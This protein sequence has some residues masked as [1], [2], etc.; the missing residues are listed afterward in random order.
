MKITKILKALLIALSIVMIFSLV[1]CDIFSGENET[2][3]ESISESASE[4]ESVSDSVPGSESESVADS[5]SESEDESDSKAE[6]GSVSESESASKSEEEECKHANT[7]LDDKCNSVCSDCGVTVATN[8]HVA[9]APD[10]E[11]A[12]NVKCTNCGKLMEANKHTAGEPDANDNCNVKC[13]VCNE[14]LKTAQHQRGDGKPDKN[15]GCKI[16]CPVCSAVLSVKHGETAT[17]W[18]PILGV[19]EDGN[20]YE[21]K[22]CVD[23]GTPRESR[24][25]AKHGWLNTVQVNGVEVAKSQAVGS[26]VTLEEGKNSADKIFVGGWVAIN[27]GVEKYVYRVI[28]ANGNA[29]AWIEVVYVDTVKPADQAIIDSVNGVKVDGVSIGITGFESN[30]LFNGGIQT[31]DLSDYIGMTVTVEFAVVPANNRGTDGEPNAIV[32][33]TVENLD[34]VC[35]HGDNENEYAVS[36]NDP[37]W[38]VSESCSVCGEPNVKIFADVNL[39][40]KY[41]FSPS[42]IASKKGTLMTENG[43]NFVRIYASK[44]ADAEENFYL[45]SST[46]AIT[47]ADGYL[48]VLYRSSVYNNIEVFINSNANAIAGGDNKPSDKINVSTEW[49]LVIINLTEKANFDE[50]TVKC[51]RF[52]QFNTGANNRTAEDYVDI[53]FIS[54]FDTPADA[55]EYYA[56]YVDAYFGEDGCYHYEN[57]GVWVAV[58]GQDC[59]IA[60]TCTYCGGYAKIVECPHDK[61]NLTNETP[62][63]N[64][65]IFSATADCALCGKKGIKIVSDKTPGGLHIFTPEYIASKK[66]TIMTDDNGLSFVRINSTKASGE[67]YFSLYSNANE[68]MTN[69]GGYIAILYRSTVTDF[70]DF[71]IDSTSTGVSETARTTKL[72][73]TG[74]TWRLIIKDHT[75]AQKFDGEKLVAFRFDVFNDAANRTNNDYVDVAY[76]AFFT[77][78]EEAEAYYAAY[79]AEYLGE[80]GCS[81]KFTTDWEKT[82][83]EGMIKN[84]CVWCEGEIVKACT[85]SYGSS[86]WVKGEE[87]GTLENTCTVCDMVV[88]KA[89]EHSF[90]DS[91]WVLNE[92]TGLVKNTCLVCELLLEFVCEHKDKLVCVIAEDGSYKYICDV[93]K[94]DSGI[95]NE[96]HTVLMPDDL[97]NKITTLSSANDTMGANKAFADILGLTD[98]NYSDIPFVRVQ[99][100]KK[101][102]AEGYIYIKFSPAQKNVGKYVSIIYRSHKLTADEMFI[103]AAASV[104]GGQNVSAKAFNSDTAMWTY[105]IFDF[106]EKTNWDANTGISTIRWD[107]NNGANVGYYLDIAYVGFFN[108]VAEAEAFYAAY[109]EQYDLD[110]TFRG[111]LDNVKI[112]GTAVKSQMPSTIGSGATFEFD[113]ADREV[114][115]IDGVELQGWF[116]SSKGVENYTIRV[117]DENGETKDITYKGADHA[118]VYGAY[119]SKA[120]YNYTEECGKGATFHLKISLEGFEGKTVDVVIIANTVDGRQIVYANL[121]NITAPAAAE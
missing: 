33:G 114:T 68:P 85:H 53:G 102:S 11:D 75:L 29:G 121:Y 44:P 95:T 92:E 49:Q 1:A 15:D 8:Q 23:C 12:C 41:V 6:S 20:L 89:C 42:Y 70:F 9:G 48:A 71:Y 78:K 117:T 64:D 2:I 21:S 103:S 61:A 69:V 57:D 10:A 97:V 110:Y 32:I 73:P 22:N 63:E 88:V 79:V 43:L 93:C 77:S 104:A 31:G 119:G 74:D 5:N 106:S 96:D 47:N 105:Q 113:F 107:I 101:T 34:V 3:E 25:V 86:E 65:P 16:K 56:A 67:D 112:D 18:A 14:T 116:L 4:G 111:H 50:E 13:T 82:D 94:Q 72:G 52:D 54:F 24:I 120:P 36:A 59:K 108:S 98:P 100:N 37:Q 46:T 87:A 109:A 39:D 51:L 62:V 91:N 7:A 19:N 76:I 58:E 30:A 28:D 38:L 80:E 27:G 115:K 90:D 26:I 81:H 118:A 66:G 17:V 45:Y 40:G 35:F 99:I 84:T 60:C 83:D 55:Y